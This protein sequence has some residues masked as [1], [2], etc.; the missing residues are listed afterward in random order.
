M[1][2]TFSLAKIKK[3][4]GR[5]YALR[6]EPTCYKHDEPRFSSL[7]SQALKIVATDDGLWNFHVSVLS[8]AC[9][10]VT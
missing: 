10:F 7:E 9:E 8:K 3:A 4:V 2:A 1:A 6:S 5:F